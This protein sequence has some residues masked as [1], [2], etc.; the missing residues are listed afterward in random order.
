MYSVSLADS[1]RAKY[2]PE[3]G[4]DD[5]EFI[6]KCDVG[7][8]SRKFRKEH[9][10]VAATGHHM[11]TQRLA[12]SVTCIS[13]IQKKQNKSHPGPVFHTFKDPFHC[14]S[15]LYSRTK[16]SDR[17]RGF[18]SVYQCCAWIKSEMLKMLHGPSF[19]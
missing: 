19:L 9:N 10:H 16:P 8:E 17:S 4:T 15:T 3:L 2:P 5:S 7:Q 6:V 11:W 14:K 12:F 1:S 18:A 13:T